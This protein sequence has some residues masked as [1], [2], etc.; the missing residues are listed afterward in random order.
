[1]YAS[2]D[3]RCLCFLKLTIGFSGLTLLP[4]CCSIFRK[5]K[6]FK[7]QLYHLQKV[8]E[9]QYTFPRK[10]YVIN[11]V[12]EDLPFVCCVNP[13]KTHELKLKLLNFV[14]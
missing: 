5:E 10:R 12:N 2:H 8:M 4:L 1:M 7:P 9:L 13:E 11:E 14:Y 3:F 6:K